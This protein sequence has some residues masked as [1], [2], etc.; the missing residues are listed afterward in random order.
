M[1]GMRP[2]LTSLTIMWWLMMVA[3]MLPSAT[4][5]LL[6]YSRVRQVRRADAGVAQ[7]WVFLSGYLAAWGLFA[8]AAALAQSRL[9]DSSMALHSSAA[10]AGLLIVAGLY[11]LSPFKAVCIWKCRSPTHS[12]AATGDPV[13][14]AQ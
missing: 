3:M 10:Q 5:A 4:P 9:T 2:P 14:M 7:T 11:Q 6:L 13:G 12:S 1:E 8:I